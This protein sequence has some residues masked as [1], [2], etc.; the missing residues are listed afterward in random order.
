LNQSK[1]HIKNPSDLLYIFTNENEDEYKKALQEFITKHRGKKIA[2][3]SATPMALLNLIGATYALNLS[4]PEDLGILGYDNLHWTRL[5]GGGIS[6]IDQNFYDVGIESAKLLIK[7]I[8]GKASG[9]SNEKCKY[10]ELESKLVLR[11]ST[12][13]I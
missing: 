7:R 12:K 13:I 5:I 4:I 2:A 9:K 6:V 11:N 8:R 1:Q 3:F 10:I